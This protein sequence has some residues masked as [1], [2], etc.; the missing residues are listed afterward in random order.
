MVY[1]IIILIFVC[2]KIKPP[3][4]CGELYFEKTL[5]VVLIKFVMRRS[6]ISLTLILSVLALLI[7]CVT[8]LNEFQPESP[9]EE[10][11]K[12]ALVKS[13]SAWNNNDIPEYLA[14]LH[15]RGKFMYGKNRNI[16][17]KKEFAD[18]ISQIKTIKPRF[19]F[20]KPKIIITGDKA[21]VNLN[22]YDI[23]GGWPWTL[24]MVRENEK[25]Y[26]MRNVYPAP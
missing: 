24:H 6:L 25:W 17:S 19:R 26:I 5:H 15:D 4:L 18:R 8:P 2:N 14:V 1:H 16:I 7:G 11:I 3:V 20:G 23:P 10:A 13:E 9:E 12:S 21:V 22:D